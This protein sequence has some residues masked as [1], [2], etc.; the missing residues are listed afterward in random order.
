MTQLGNTK[1]LK[2]L[3]GYLHHLDPKE[4]ADVASLLTEFFIFSD[5]P[6]EKNVL[7]HNIDLIL[8]QNP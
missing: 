5:V 3:D 7:E 6:A 1:I 2:N 4:V 8:M